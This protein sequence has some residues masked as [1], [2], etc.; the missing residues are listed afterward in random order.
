MKCLVV[1]TLAGCASAP[2]PQTVSLP[3]VLPTPPPTSTTSPIQNAY[4][5]EPDEA[6]FS[7]ERGIVRLTRDGARVSGAYPNGV[8]VCETRSE[9]LACEWFEPS[10]EGQASF[11]RASDGRF[12]GTY[13]NGASV[14]DLGSWTLTPIPRANLATMDGAWDT[15]WGL[16]TLKEAQGTLHV[17][18]PGGQMDCAHQGAKSLD[19]TWVEGS[20]SGTAQFAIESPRVL[21]GRWATTTTL[22]GAW[23]FVRR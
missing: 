15:N 18:Y 2:L 19:C 17:D 5:P 22:T 8:L 20:L 7:S 3:T 16:A 11:H 21:R 9:A 13:G 14:D 1:L 4:P 23:V 10:A 6:Q 12:M